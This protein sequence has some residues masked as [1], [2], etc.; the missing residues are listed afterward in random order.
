MSFVWIV[1]HARGEYDDFAVNIDSV[2]STKEGGEARLSYLD[3]QMEAKRLLLPE[4]E[5][6]HQ[7]YCDSLRGTAFLH[8][9]SKM[10]QEQKD[11][12]LANSNE[13]TAMF[14]FSDGT[15]FDDTSEFSIEEWPL[16]VVDK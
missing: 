16:D 14:K 3:E 5:K 8:D 12:L 13:R 10:T 11:T 4:M 9:Y 2:W 6:R 15:Y 1:T 7:E